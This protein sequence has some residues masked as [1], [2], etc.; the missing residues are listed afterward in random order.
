MRSFILVLLFLRNFEQAYA[1]VW[2]SQDN[3]KKERKIY[4]QLK[5]DLYR[6]K[7]LQL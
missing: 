2:I 7:N 4:K 5:K 1:F 3:V 6:H